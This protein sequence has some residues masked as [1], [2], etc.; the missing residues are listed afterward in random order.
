VDPRIVAAVVV[1]QAVSATLAYRD[2]AHRPDEAVRGP[3]LFWRM[4]VPL[5]L[6]NSIAYWLFGRRSV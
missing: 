2:L 4:V 5:N 1:V 3:K 6:G